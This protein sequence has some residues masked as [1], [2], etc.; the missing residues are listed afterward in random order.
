MANV[1]LTITVEVLAYYYEYKYF[2]LSKIFVVVFIVFLSFFFVIQKGK[3]RFYF[4]H[5]LYFF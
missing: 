2:V 4:G 5:G 1:W 3:K